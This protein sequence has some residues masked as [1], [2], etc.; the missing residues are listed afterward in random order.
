MTR[1]PEPGTAK[2]DEPGIGWILLKFALQ[3]AIGFAAFAALVWAGIIVLLA[4]AAP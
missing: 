1:P 4:A 2:P 3:C